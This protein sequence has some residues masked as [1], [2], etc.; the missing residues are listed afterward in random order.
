M[1]YSQLRAMLAITRASLRSIFRSP[2]AVVFSFVFPF[3]FIIVFGFIGGSS[4]MQSYKIVMADGADT[5]NELYAALKNS[6]N[7]K[8]LKYNP[9][10]LKTAQQKGSIAGILNIIKTVGTATPFKIEFKSTTSSN[11][12]WPQFKALLESKINELSNTKFQNRPTYASFDFN[13]PRDVAVIR[14]YK[15]I[16]FILPGQLGFSLLSAGVFGVAFTFFS[17]RNTLVLK[18]FFATPISKTY[19]I[20]GEGLSRVIFQMIT[21]IVIIGAGYLFFGFTLVHGWIT[22]L[23]MLF[24][25]FLGLLVFMGCGFI[26]SGLAKTDSTIPPLAN[27][28][29]LPQFLLGGTFFSI[30]NFPG[31]L[32]PISK[33]LPLTYLNTAMRK[34]AFEGLNLW[35]VKLEI[36]ILFIWG[37]IVYAAAVKAFKWE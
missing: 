35:D 33:A 18:R 20:L 25:S 5:T 14:Q 32:Q 34:V 21:A 7:V 8:I 22:F 29:T 31:W 3:V 15:T 12:R 1:R 19:I 30:D 36:G 2:S 17:L 6:S 28:I 16:D 37:I 11:D 26:I 9:D 13:V 4:G 23:E 24:L 10:E 27:L